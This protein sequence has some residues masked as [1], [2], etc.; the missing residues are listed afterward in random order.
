M[1][2]SDLGCA[3]LLAVAVTIFVVICV[4]AMATT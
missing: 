4:V 1:G 3:I 2:R